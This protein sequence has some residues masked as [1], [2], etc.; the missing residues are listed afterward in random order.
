MVPASYQL[1]N[2]FTE[3][4]KIVLNKVKLIVGNIDS[5]NNSTSL[6]AFFSMKLHEKIEKMA[7]LIQNMFKD[8]NSLCENYMRYDSKKL[9][10]EPQS[11]ITM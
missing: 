6:Y 7:P 1:L 11:F 4:L 10:E 3:F 2:N 8:I 5:N 9:I